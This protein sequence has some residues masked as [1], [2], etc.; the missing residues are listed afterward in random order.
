MTDSKMRSERLN[1]PFKYKGALASPDAIQWREAMN[2]DMALLD[3]LNTWE[4]VGL[5]TPRKL[6]KTK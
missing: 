2:E 3:R 5:P 1:V 6:V 4:L